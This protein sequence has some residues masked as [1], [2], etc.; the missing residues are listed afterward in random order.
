[1]EGLGGGATLRTLALIGVLLAAVRAQA[2]QAR[3]YAA[4]ES[5]SKRH[6]PGVNTPLFP[7]FAAGLP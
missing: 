4:E 6:D 7:A 1:V 2:R 3:R 5:H